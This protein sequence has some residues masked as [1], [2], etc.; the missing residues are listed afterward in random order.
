MSQRL[1]HL[2]FAPRR[3]GWGARLLLLAGSALVLTAGL[4]WWQVDRETLALRELVAQRTASTRPVMA[5]RSDPAVSTQAREMSRALATPW[6][7]MLTDLETAGLGS[8]D[9]IA[10]LGIVPDRSRSRI[11]LTA[12]AR[13]LPAALQYLRRL[14]RLPS[15]RNAQLQNHE[16]RRD[17]PEMP[18]H[19]EIL[20]DWRQAT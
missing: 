7:R 14:Q 6:S 9:D 19:V 1:V 15:L 17:A 12:E 18:V 20:A 16:V 5:R 11:V 10:L 13:S 4:L 2:D 3:S 8:G